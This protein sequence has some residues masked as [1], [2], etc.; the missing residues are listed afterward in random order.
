MQICLCVDLANTDY[1]AAT[2]WCGGLPEGVFASAFIIINESNKH[3]L[4]QSRTVH[5]LTKTEMSDYVSAL[6]QSRSVGAMKVEHQKI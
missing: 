3:N 1:K 5:L 6:L 4:M 2:Q